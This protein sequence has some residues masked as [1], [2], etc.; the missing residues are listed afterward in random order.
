M[1]LAKF[2][3]SFGFVPLSALLTLG[4]IVVSSLFTVIGAKNYLETGQVSFDIRQRASGV[5]CGGGQCNDGWSFGQDCSAPQTTCSQRN[6]EACKDHGGI[7]SGGGPINCGSTQTSTTQ[8]TASQTTTAATGEI[9]NGTNTASECIG[10]LTG[11][12]CASGL[13]SCTK[14]GTAGGVQCGCVLRAG[15]C[16]TEG[17]ANGKPCC[18]GIKRANG[19]CASPGENPLPTQAP[20]SVCPSGQS[21]CGGCISA[22]QNT[23]TKT[24]NDWIAEKCN[25]TGSATVKT[26]PS[27]TQIAAIQGCTIAGN[28]Y[29]S[30]VCCDGQKP[31]VVSG[32]NFQICPTVTPLPAQTLECIM[33]G[34]PF[35][36]GR[37]CCDGQQP[38]TN[39]MAFKQCPATATPNQTLLADNE[40]CQSNSQCQSGRCARNEFNETVCLNSSYQVKKRDGQAC[41]QNGDCQSNLCLQDANDIYKCTSI[42]STPPP[43]NDSLVLGNPTNTSHAQQCAYAG[44]TRSILYWQCVSPYTPNTNKNGCQTVGADTPSCVINGPV[45]GQNNCCA[46]S[47]ASFTSGLNQYVCKSCVADGETAITSVSCCNGRQPSGGVCL[48][49][50]CD[51]NKCVLGCSNRSYD[52]GVCNAL[53]KEGDS[54]QINSQCQTGN[55]SRNE[56]N[57]QVC[58]PYGYQTKKANG[59]T[60][61]HSYDCLSGY[62]IGDGNGHYSCQANNP[63]NLPNCVT[64]NVLVD[65]ANS[66][67]ASQCKTVITADQFTNLYWQC[68]AGYHPGAGSTVC[69]LDETPALN[70]IPL[71]TVPTCEQAGGFCSTVCLG[72][73]LVTTTTQGCGFTRQCWRKPTPTQTPT[74]QI[75]A[76]PTSTKQAGLITPSSPSP[77]LTPEVSQ[78]PTA[79]ITT[80]PAL[81]TPTAELTPTPSPTPFTLPQ[82]QSAFSSLT[83][84]IANSSIGQGVTKLVNLVTKGKTTYC[85]GSKL[86]ECLNQ[87]M[88]CEADIWGGR[89]AAPLLTPA[90]TIGNL[91]VEITTT[92]TPA[93]A[94][95]TLPQ[96]CV[97]HTNDN[98]CCGPGLARQERVACGANAE[99]LTSFGE[100]NIQ[101][102][103]CG[104][105]PPGGNTP[106][107]VSNNHEYC[108]NGY[109]YD[110]QPPLFWSNCQPTQCAVGYIYDDNTTSC[111]PISSNV[112]QTCDFYG[113][114]VK[115]GDSI[116]NSNTIMRCVNPA[117]SNEDQWDAQHCLAGLTC[118][119][120]KCVTP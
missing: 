105:L 48:S 94:P 17:P 100:C 44:T 83:S 85:S 75:T 72:C 106:S 7:K 59:Q 108:P 114:A 23:S 2:R 32:A 68:N 98:I 15:T 111:I 47:Y 112:P 14:N 5:S 52:G 91:S 34:L 29:T 37:V 67:H 89:C 19:E 1:N 9:C 110:T 74:P 104:T 16:T 51:Q 20:G 33:P 113:Q 39:S 8:T 90:A 95:I 50:Y 25:Q 96:T 65:G 49:Q 87:N 11:T 117:N 42:T 27:P 60:C 120:G 69:T 18:S 92:P 76:T 70:N 101:T 93:R 13:G 63:A 10:K 6:Q 62:C 22:C 55:C 24:C 66:G 26:S 54:C 35:I 82:V 77:T 88:R 12:S 4:V 86:T 61:V 102:E 116:C 40:S 21:Y 30:G 107:I 103:T 28:R 97:P 119:S 78:I 46:G 58:L 118:R 43:C 81:I 41:T 31:T 38:F 115:P 3:H 57:E 64:G 73:S 53:Y 80:T 79:P 36:E 56:N 84:T 99:E 109:Q 71:P 45:T